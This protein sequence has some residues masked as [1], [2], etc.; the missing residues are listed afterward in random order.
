MKFQ[1]FPRFKKLREKYE[2]GNNLGVSIIKKSLFASALMLCIACPSADMAAAAKYMPKELIPSGRVVGISVKSDGV[3]VVSLGE[4]ETSGGK[5]TPAADAGLLSGDIIKNIGSVTIASIDDVKK[6]IN[7]AE[8]KAL[9][10]KIERSGKSMQFFITPALNLSGGYELG[11]WLREGLAGMGTVTFVDPK[12][13]VVGVLGH[14]INDS[15]AKVLLPIKSG[16]LLGASVGS[17]VKGRCGTPG[18]LQGDL[19][20]DKKIATI[21]SNTDCGVFGVTELEELLK[22]ERLPVCLQKE[23]KVGGA[24]ILSNISGEFEYYSIEISKVYPG[25]DERNMLITVTDERLIS[26]TG[27]IVQG[28][29]GSPII[30]SGKIAGAVTHV[31]VNE[32]EKGYGISVEKMLEKA[33]SEKRQ[34]AA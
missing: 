8:G 5:I 20:F 23:I 18:Q 21:Y 12:S 29:S 4:V 10:L 6:S 1:D 27:G 15:E 7:M 31:L 2:I 9:S 32:P 17:I 34:M 19:D 22:G 24:S 25:S 11:V 28:M 16:M 14:P 3:M 26:Q 13:G 33:F 30:Q